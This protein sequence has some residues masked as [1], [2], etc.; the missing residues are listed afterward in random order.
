MA[1]SD[2]WP[3]IKKRG[4]MSTSA[5]LDHFGIKGR[6]RS[7]IEAAHRPEKISL[8][9]EGSRVVLRDQKPMEPQRL[10]QG[11]IDGTTVS[12]WYKLINGKVFFWAEES[13]LLRLLNARHYRDLTHDVLTINTA[14][15]VK[16]YE[17]AIWLSHMNSGNTLPVPHPRGMDLFKKISAYPVNKRGNRPAKEVVELVVDYGVPDIAAHVTAIRRMKGSTV[18]EVQEL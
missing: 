5:V 4:L 9:V 2:T 8:G 1:E 15:L 14:S 13:R 12:E 3:S 17:N 11:L 18:L 7:L 16:K 6:E 10:Q